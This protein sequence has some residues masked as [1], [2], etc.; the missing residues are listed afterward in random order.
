MDSVKCFFYNVF[1][2]TALFFPCIFVVVMKVLEW[3]ANR[4]CACVQC[5]FV[6]FKIYTAT[7][8]RTKQTINVTIQGNDNETVTSKSP[9]SCRVKTT[10]LLKNKKPFKEKEILT[11]AVTNSVRFPDPFI[12]NNQTRTVEERVTRNHAFRRTGQ[13]AAGMTN[14]L[15][16]L[17]FDFQNKDEKN[18]KLEKG[19]ERIKDGVKLRPNQYGGHIERKILVPKTVLNSIG[20]YRGLD[21]YD[22]NKNTSCDL[23]DHDK[24]LDQI[25]MTK[26]QANQSST[27]ILKTCSVR[28]WSVDENAEM[29]NPAIHQRQDCCN[30]NETDESPPETG[31]KI[32]N[33]NT[34][35][36][37][38]CENSKETIKVPSK[39]ILIVASKTMT[40]FV[41]DATKSI[42]IYAAWQVERNQKL[43]K[44]SLLLMDMANAVVN[45]VLNGSFRFVNAQL[46]N[47]KNSSK[48]L[49]RNSI[50]VVSATR[51]AILDTIRV[52]TALKH[53]IQRHGKVIREAMTRV[54]CKTGCVICSPFT[55]GVRVLRS[56]VAS[57][58]SHLNEA[59]SQLITSKSAKQDITSPKMTCASS[60]ITNLQQDDKSAD[61]N[62]A[63]QVESSTAP[64]EDQRC[65][66]NLSTVRAGGISSTS[67]HVRYSEYSN[68]KKNPIIKPGSQSNSKS[69]HSRTKESF[70][71]NNNKEKS[72]SA[73]KKV[74][75]NISS[76]TGQRLYLPELNR[77]HPKKSSKG[78][79]KDC[80]SLLS[81]LPSS[82]DESSK[83]A[84]KRM[85]KQKKV[86]SAT[87]TDTPIRVISATCRDTPSS[88]LSAT[89]TDKPVPVILATCIDT[90]TF[91][92]I[93]SACAD[94]PALTPTVA[95]E[96]NE[97]PIPRIIPPSQVNTVANGK[98]I[99]TTLSSVNVN[100]ESEV[101][102]ACN[103]VNRHSAEI[104]NAE[105]LPFSRGKR[106]HIEKE[107][108]SVYGQTPASFI[109][110]FK[111]NTAVPNTTTGIKVPHPLELR[112]NN[113]AALSS[114]GEN[115][116]GIDT[117]SSFKNAQTG[118]QSFLSISHLV[119]GGTE[120]K[121]EPMEIGES[122]EEPF[123]IPKPEAMEVSY[124]SCQMTGESCFV[125]VPS[126]NSAEKQEIEEMET[127]Q[128]H[129][130]VWSF[131]PFPLPSFS[132][133]PFT[134]PSAVEEM[135]LDEQS[136]VHVTELEKMEVNE[137]VFQKTT[138][139]FGQHEKAK[140]SALA[141]GM[142]RSVTCP[143]Q[144]QVKLGFRPFV[145]PYGEI[146]DTKRPLASRMGV[147]GETAFPLKTASA[148][149]RIM[150]PGTL[151][152][153]PYA[154]TPSVMQPVM[155]RLNAQIAMQPADPA[156]VQSKVQAVTQ[157]VVMSTT[158][159][160]TQQMSQPV[161]QSYTFPVVQTVSQTEA[162]P[163]SQQVTQLAKHLSPEPNAHRLLRPINE[164]ETLPKSEQSLIY[165]S[166]ETQLDKNTSEQPLADRELTSTPEELLANLLEINESETNSRSRRDQ[167]SMD[168]QLQLVPSINAA[169]LDT[170]SDSESEFDSD[171]EFELDLETIEKFSYLESSPDHARLITKI[172]NEKESTQW[173]SVSDLHSNGNNL[174]DKHGLNEML[175]LN[176][177][178]RYSELE[179][180]IERS[181]E[182]ADHLAKLLA[183]KESLSE[184][185]HM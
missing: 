160:L 110:Q 169:H 8:Q 68:M 49:A 147:F 140:W 35:Q 19:N 185:C 83:V 24:Q 10:S 152:Q 16:T 156:A 138:T 34:V 123:R 30:S 179:D 26:P 170:V 32:L 22:Q 135:E 157:P 167:L 126:T 176:V 144:Q 21:Y 155:Q 141:T 14:S 166:E 80:E 106:P 28:L 76:S 54:L 79:L 82:G 67:K 23:T 33:N 116:I 95:C 15:R 36:Q 151:Q 184:L 29:K 107:R 48:M 117:G 71:R 25:Q 146:A 4:I 3:A 115:T 165:S 61:D 60:I 78:T 5:V 62:V 161:I 94:T 65:V 103:S 85:K 20:N 137:E 175:D 127:E 139:P 89:C 163:K 174:A 121:P 180:E 66:G 51:G 171:D 43:R 42:C 39:S 84:V 92:V 120:T 136:S 99:R 109:S 124:E 150:Q 52:Q 122:V 97:K 37:E 72:R 70:Q 44:V 18:Y 142:E 11:K 87:C 154:A 153:V 128:E 73:V 130:S 158:Q 75:L 101:I 164:T 46:R 105:D 134:I 162:Q 38:N 41:Q 96:P 2:I 177:I 86:I 159:S 114:A 63:H 74:Q 119:Q 118:L 98:D 143:L 12:S 31:T 1:L 125:Q 149:Q 55:S 77:K 172:M 168:E 93:S 59:V 131:F 181:P 6:F 53:S 178:E 69:L 132:A 183:E 145:S 57:S 129:C 113:F 91:G 133:S 40:N 108:T 102:R 64:K 111:F 45:I 104:Q 47:I 27:S 148:E 173:H 90:T 9:E 17:Y 58:T 56:A 81:M 88:A 100:A 112:N 50:I 7:K 13:V 182:Y